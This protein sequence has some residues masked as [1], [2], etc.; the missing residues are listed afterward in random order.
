MRSVKQKLLDERGIALPVA[1]MVL[2]MAAGLAMVAARSGIVA[3]HQSYRD[4]NVKSAIQAAQ[5]GLQVTLYRSNVLQPTA[6]QCVVKDAGT[7]ALSK[8]AVQADGWCAPQTETMGDGASYTVQ[9]SQS[10]NVRINGQMLAERKIVATG[11][12]N[13]VSRRAS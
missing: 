8:T 9:M 11:T 3:T 4:S 5:S 6:T 10:A 1:M 2:F 7:G 12:A 13:G